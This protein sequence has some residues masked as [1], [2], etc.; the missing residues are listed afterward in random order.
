MKLIPFEFSTTQSYMLL[1]VHNRMYIFKNKEL[2]TN[3]NSSG[4]D[5]LTTTI[6][7]TASCNYGSYT[8]SRY[9]DCGPGRYGS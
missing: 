9:I 1:F 7:S 3:I 5:Y 8:I 4:N 6:G 2:V